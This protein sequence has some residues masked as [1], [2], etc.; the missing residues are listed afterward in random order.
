MREEGDE[1]IGRRSLSHSRKHRSLSPTGSSS[2]P[3]D[4]GGAVTSVGGG[5]EGEGGRDPTTSLSEGG[6]FHSWSAKIAQKT[7]A[8]SMFLSL[9]RFRNQ[10]STTTNSSSSSSPSSPSTK[11][12]RQPFFTSPPEPLRRKDLPRVLSAERLHHNN[13]NAEE[14]KENEK[15]NENENENENETRNV[16]ETMKEKPKP[17][18]EEKEKEKGREEEKEEEEEDPHYTTLSDSKKEAQRDKERAHYTTLSESEY[19]N[20]FPHPPS[21]TSRP[22]GDE[23]ESKGEE[24]VEGILSYPVLS[25]TV[26]SYSYPLMYLYYPILSYPIIHYPSCNIFCIIFCIILYYLMLSYPTLFN[27]LLF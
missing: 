27:L 20:A 5:G 23:E 13:I 4:S 7:N 11:H 15:E 14:E 1:R 21:N 26:L 2:S 22:E 3:R 9:R 19:E 10:N 6:G 25:C 17:K 24:D 8:S 18:E 12:P 16:T